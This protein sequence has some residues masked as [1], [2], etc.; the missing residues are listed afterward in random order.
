MLTDKARRWSAG[1]LTPIARGLSALGLSPDA[2]T[3]L[4]LLFNMGV[5]WV[6][7]WGPGW[8]GWG[9]L[10][11]ILAS[12]FDAF[13]GAVARLTNRVTPFG[14]F[15]DSTL[16][17]LSEASIYLGLL[18]WYITTTPPHTLEPVLI[19]LTIVGSIMVSYT[20]ARAEGLGLQMKEGWFTRLERMIVV[21][22][23]LAV[24]AYDDRLMQVV[25]LALALG[26]NITVVQRILST[27]SKLR[28]RE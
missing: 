24:S 25:L 3:V 6:L 14:A 28:N 17:R 19:Y 16:D 9:A 1:I 22:V 10:L 11:L 5:A 8:W 7:A 15:L 21:I 23:G 2:L 13:D 4:G 26:T 20:R 18:Y 12:I 27:R